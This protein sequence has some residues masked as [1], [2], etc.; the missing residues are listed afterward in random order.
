M[1]R[2]SYIM[3]I[4]LLI[5]SLVVVAFFS[6]YH[7]TLNTHNHKNSKEKAISKKLKE[8]SLEEILSTKATL[9]FVNSKLNKRENFNLKVNI[10]DLLKVNNINDFSQNFENYNLRLNSKKVKKKLNFYD[11]KS[12]ALSYFVRQYEIFFEVRNNNELTEYKIVDKNRIENYLFDLQVKGFVDGK[13]KMLSDDFYFNLN[14]DFSNL[15]E[16]IF[17]N[18]IQNTYSED[19]RIYDYKEKIYFMYNEQYLKLLKDYLSYKGFESESIDINLCD[20]DNLKNCSREDFIKN[21]LLESSEY[22]KDYKYNI[23]NIDVRNKLYF[24]LNTEVEIYSNIKINDS[25]EIIVTDKSPKIQGVF[26]NKSNKE[27]FDFN[28]EGI[29]FSKNKLKSKYK[30]LPEVLDLT[31]RF[32]KIS[33]NFYLEKIQKNDIK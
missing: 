30:F 27:K 16:R 29:L 9:D 20:I 31:A 2:K 17:S 8:M 28:F 18:E 1:K 13:L 25:S 32:V 4:V 6:I 33:E 19:L 22:I 3:P 10:N 5:F 11:R 15:Y 26:V 7:R 14:N 21:F 23:I 12:G 24:D